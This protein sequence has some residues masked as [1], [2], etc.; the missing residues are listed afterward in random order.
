MDGSIYQALGT[1]TATPMN[2]RILT[3]KRPADFALETQKFVKQ[4]TGFTVELRATR[5]FHDRFIILDRTR[6]YLLG[7]SVKDA[8]N[9]GFT[10]VPLQEPSIVRFILDHADQVWA[11]ATPL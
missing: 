5:D 6:C 9:K 10:I 4:H 8:G 11:S 3:S 2:V 7:A 1:L